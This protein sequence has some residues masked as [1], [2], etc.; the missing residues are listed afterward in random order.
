MKREF[1][2][3]LRGSIQVTYGDQKESQEDYDTF[4]VTYVTTSN[5]SVGNET[6]LSFLCNVFIV[7][8][9]QGL[10]DNGRAE[11]LH[12]LGW[13]GGVDVLSF[14]FVKNAR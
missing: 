2:Y 14:G 6:D 1:I 5:F 10:I 4:A 11:K 13:R 8:Y 7:K 12:E 3:D 9:C